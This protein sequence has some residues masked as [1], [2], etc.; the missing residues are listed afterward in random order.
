MKPKK[1]KFKRQHSSKK[2]VQRTGWKHPRGIDSEQ[3]E[4]I[5]SKG[6]HP[7]VGYGSPKATKGLH[8]T[9]V[10]EV[11]VKTFADLSKVGEGMAAR[12]HSKLGKRKR[13]LITEQAK[14]KKIKVLN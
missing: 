13:A 3:R 10:K 8:P 1:P 12:L 2:R 11:L 14:E 4:H 9:G 6:A 7:R 5:K